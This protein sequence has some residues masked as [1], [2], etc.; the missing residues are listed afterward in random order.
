MPF[1]EGV[2]HFVEDEVAVAPQLRDLGLIAFSFFIV[3]VLACLAGALE[4]DRRD[5]C[6]QLRDQEE[7]SGKAFATYVENA[8]PSR[9]DAHV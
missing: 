8:V 7:R 6:G 9:L 5:A 1:T 4:V 2:G 3:A